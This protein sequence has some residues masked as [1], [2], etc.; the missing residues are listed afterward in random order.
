MS[1]TDLSQGTIIHAHEHIDPVFLNTPQFELEALNRALGIRTVLKVET[2]NPIRSFKGRGTDYFV[3]N[4]S[5]ESTFVCASAGNFGQGMAYACRKN[6]I[7]LVVFAATTANPLKIEQMRRLGADIHLAG[8]D[9]DGAKDAGKAYAAENGG[10]FVEDGKVAEVSIGAGTIGLE[11]SQYPDPIDT[12]LIPLGNGAL[13]NGVGTWFKASFPKTKV[14][15]VVAEN[16]PS[17][18]LSWCRDLVVTTETAETISDGIAVR[19]PVP[20]ALQIMKTTVDD[21]VQVSDEAT[22]KAMRLVYN[23]A[24]IVI[25]P[26]G[27]VGLAAAMMFKKRL[28]GQIIATPLCGSNMT[29]EQIAGWL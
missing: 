20:E 17:M 16:A 26:A 2:L 4:S 15:G 28:L 3:Q 5:Q 23:F 22:I 10:V 18:Q 11:L 19:H 13:I 12:L 27:A 8:A 7:S 1:K 21:I 24:G 6:Q 25:E 9:F 29:V 14:I